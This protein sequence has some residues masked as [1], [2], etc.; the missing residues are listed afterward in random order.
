MH[1]G[2][3]QLGKVNDSMSKI[4]REEMQ[5]RADETDVVLVHIVNGSEK[6]KT[7]RICMG[8]EI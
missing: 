4:F 8:M 1:I 3:D 5:R 7:I 6:G 2:V